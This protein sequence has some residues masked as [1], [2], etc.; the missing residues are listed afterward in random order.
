MSMTGKRLLIVGNSHTQM[1]SKALVS[2][3]RASALPVDIEVCWL[4][5]KGKGNFGDT[6]REDAQAKIAALKASDLLAVSFLGTLHNLIGLFEHPSPYAI[7]DS[8]ND[9][10]A[11]PPNAEIIPHK[12]MIDLFDQ[13]TEDDLQVRKFAGIATCPVVHFFPPPPKERYAKPRKFKVIDGKT[14]EF[15]FASAL[16]RLNLWKLETLA[17]ERYLQRAGVVHYL[18]PRG[19]ADEQGYLRPEYYASDATHANAAYG[20]L[21][22]EDFERMLD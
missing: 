13:F 5:S 2:R 18:C 19:S 21:L 11:I 12:V 3:S 15:R 22:I 6:S 10:G 20:E 14:V 4:L 17:V 16:A 1:I 9:S 7:L 8:Q